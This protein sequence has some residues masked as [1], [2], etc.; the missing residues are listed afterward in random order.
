M[1]PPESVTVASV[2]WWMPESR[3]SSGLHAP[4][5]VAVDVDQAVLLVLQ[6][7][8]LVEGLH[9]PDGGAEGVG[10]QRCAVVDLAAGRVDARV[11]EDVVQDV[12][13]RLGQL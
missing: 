6:P 7:V 3:W 1:P 8:Y 9:A 12:A 10:Y 13:R 11:V 5:A 2:R 4:A